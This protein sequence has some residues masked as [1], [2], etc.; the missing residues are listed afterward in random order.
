MR[1][2]S[3]TAPP[4]AVVTGANRGLGF[5][6]AEQLASSGAR[7]V[8]TARDE[9]RAADA[10]AALVERGLE[11][12]AYRARLDVSCRRSVATFAAFCARELDGAPDVLVNNAGVC[13]EGWTEAVV[14]RAVRTNVLGPL[15]LTRL[16]L[17]A[18]V[19]RGRGQ[20]LSVSSGDGE[21]C[22]LSPPLQD[23]LRAVDSHAALLRLLARAAPPRDAYGAAPAHGPSPAYSLSKAALNLSLIHI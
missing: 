3:P 21:L 5:A 22:Y 10:A 6:L 18:M 9:R 1:T 17:P 11:V 14:R 16:L 12:Q 13:E 4:T 23:D 20:V 15:L 19:R 8:L 2:P 7:V